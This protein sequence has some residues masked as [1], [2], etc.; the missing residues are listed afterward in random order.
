MNSNHREEI[1][2]E[3]K[4]E[5]EFET[6]RLINSFKYAGTGIFTSLKTEKNMKIHFL[7]MFLVIILG[8]VLHISLNEWIVCIILFAGVIGG[9]MFNTA[10]ETVVDLV[11]P[12]KN[13][14]A[15]IAKDVAAGG[16]L[17]WAI[18]SAIIGGM[19]FIPKIID[20]F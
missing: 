14:K 7:A 5:M 1:K 20:L 17:V 11:T 9:E 10:I 4:E 6:K 3:I 16:V 8:F 15:K 12:Y 18:C 19:I 2:E 13:P